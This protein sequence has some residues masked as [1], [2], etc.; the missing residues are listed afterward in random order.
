MDMTNTFTKLWGS[1][2]LL[3]LACTVQA[4]I[5]LTGVFE[6]P[7]GQNNGIRNE[8]PRGIEVFLSSDIDFSTEVY[9]IRINGNSSPFVIP[10]SLGSQEEGTFLYFT[11]DADYFIEFFGFPADVVASN[12]IAVNGSTTCTVEILDNNNVVLDIYGPGGTQGTFSNGWKY[13]L[14]DT[15]NVNGTFD[16]THWYGQHKYLQSCTTNNGNNMGCVGVPIGT[17]Q[18]T[19]MPVELIEFKVNKQNDEAFI[20]WT[21]A[22]EENNAYFEVQ[23]AGAD[24]RFETIASLEGQVNS[25]VLNTY[26][27]ADITP[28][29]GMNYYR[30]VQVDVD[31]TTTVLPTRALD[32]TSKDKIICYPN[33]ASD[34]LNLQGVQAGANYTVLNVTGLVLK[35]GLMSTDQ[36]TIDD[37]PAGMYYL[38][39]QQGLDV[40]VKTFIKK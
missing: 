33:P 13:R 32:F 17:Y 16:E 11:N 14:D 6:G 22:S 29:E 4:Q 38:Q 8:Y 35:T 18:L 5:I 39:V 30:L 36:I 19:V 1:A 26:Q 23:R 9:K 27:Y 3:C 34:V 25:T 40:T 24:I 7:L 12:F 31:G 2:M 20:Q 21:T 28:F 15:Q 37:L 10:T